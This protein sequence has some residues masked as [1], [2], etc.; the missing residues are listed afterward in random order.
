VV[1]S[2]PG[3][4]A[5]G[6]VADIVTN[7]TIDL[8]KDAAVEIFDRPLV[9]GPATEN[10]T[11]I[12]YN[13][14]KDTIKNIDAPVLLKKS[15]KSTCTRSWAPA[16]R[17]NRPSRAPSWGSQAAAISAVTSSVKERRSGGNGID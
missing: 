14:T 16:A 3:A 13:Y 2:E 1:S 9:D 12:G 11:E 7:E 8:E 4:G 15:G 10:R 5:Q 17:S 6:E